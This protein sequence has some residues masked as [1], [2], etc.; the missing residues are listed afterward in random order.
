MPEQETEMKVVVR[1]TD[2]DAGEHIYT[3][4]GPLGED[5]RRLIRAVRDHIVNAMT[6]DSLGVLRMDH[7]IAWYN[8]SHLVSVTIK[9][10]REDERIPVDELRQLG[11]M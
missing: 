4:V 3:F 10:T 11:L 9:I 5:D 2:G 1:T 7:P 6:S 8:G